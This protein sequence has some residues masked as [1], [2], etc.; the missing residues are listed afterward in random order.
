MPFQLK[1]FTAA[2]I[3]EVEANHRAPRFTQRPI[4]VGVL[5]SYR[6]AMLS[7]TIAAAARTNEP[8]FSFRHGAATLCLIR[9]V[10]V[11]VGDLTGFTAGFFN[12]SLFA[13]R[14]F[15]VADT[16]GTAATLTG[17]NGKLR[18]SMVGTTGVADIRIPTTG[19]LTAGTRT[20][21][22]QP[23]GIVSGSVVATAGQPPIAPTDLLNRSPDEWPLVCAQN[24][25][26]VVQVNAPATGTWALGVT[27][28]WDE[29]TTGSWAQGA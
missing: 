6:V 7:G 1:G 28:A 14:S 9:K 11:S 18:T 16:G 26:F 29:V 10:I 5:G 22:A 19:V 17:N 27:V 23:L 2:N 15:T 13:A 24:E 21:D 25:G 20:L 4:D 12:L 8:V 3:A